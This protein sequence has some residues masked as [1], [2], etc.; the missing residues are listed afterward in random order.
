VLV[1]DDLYDGAFVA[2]CRGIRSISE[3]PLIVM[4]GDAPDPSAME[5]VRDLVNGQ[6]RK[7]FGV[8]ELFG[9]LYEIVGKSAAISAI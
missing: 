8:S 4:S 9:C 2:I 7:P 1:D 3:I 6:L 5:S